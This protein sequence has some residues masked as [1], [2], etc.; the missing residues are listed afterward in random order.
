MIGVVTAQLRTTDLE[1]S[2]RFWTE[3][4]GL[5]LDFVYGDFY[6]GISTGAGLFHLKHVDAPDP[7][8]AFVRQGD[9]FHLYL[10]TDD[11]RDALAALAAKGIHPVTPL[12]ETDWGTRE[13]A[14]LDDQGHTIYFGERLLG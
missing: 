4:V 5:E 6:A 1:A 11:A 9:H 10:D 3:A 2:I 13:F 14:I 12:H 7:S 8:I